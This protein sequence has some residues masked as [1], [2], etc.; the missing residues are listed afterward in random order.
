MVRLYGPG[1]SGGRVRPAGF[2][3][4]AAIERSVSHPAYEMRRGTNVPKEGD[5]EYHQR[6]GDVERWWARICP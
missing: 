4:D 1:A 3:T 6:I 5:A 2:S